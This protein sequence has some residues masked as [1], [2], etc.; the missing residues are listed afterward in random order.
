MTSR[1]VLP[2]FFF[3]IIVQTLQ[4]HVTQSRIWS[5]IL[6]GMNGHRRCKLSKRSLHCLPSISKK[7]QTKEEGEWETILCCS[8]R[9]LH[10]SDEPLNP[11]AKSNE[12]KSSRQGAQYRSPYLLGKTQTGI[13][14]AFSGGGGAQAAFAWRRICLFAPLP[15]C[16]VSLLFK[17]FFWG[18]RPQLFLQNVHTEEQGWDNSLGI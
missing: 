12:G 13:S 6:L 7:T 2:I 16:S 8:R 4:T 10:P 9:L 14:V 11:H 17:L 1:G 5:K 3:F 18:I 15:N